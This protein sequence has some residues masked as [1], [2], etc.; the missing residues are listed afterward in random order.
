M[1]KRGNIVPLVLEIMGFW[2]ALCECDLP[3][4]YIVLVLVG[5]NLV[6][7]TDVTHTLVIDVYMK[8]KA[9]PSY[10][11]Y[12]THLEIVKIGGRYFSNCVSIV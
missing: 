3:L 6:Y 5:I 11:V 1:A 2:S 8:A 12:P 10:I 9:Y 4:Y 7:N